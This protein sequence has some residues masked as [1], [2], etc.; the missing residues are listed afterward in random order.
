MRQLLPF[1]FE[2]P[3]EMTSRYS[4]EDTLARLRSRVAPPGERPDHSCVKGEVSAEEVQLTFHWIYRRTSATMAV[5]RGR[6]LP[7]RDG[8]QA[9][10]T[11]AFVMPLAGLL[12]GVVMFGFLAVGLLLLLLAATGFYEGPPGTGAGLVLFGALF[13]LVPL[14]R[15]YWGLWE[16][17]G[18]RAR[19]VG[20]LEEACLQ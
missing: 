9:V 4:P 17:N 20:L 8:Q 16:F 15:G 2:Q 5:F 10:L 11:G 12:F 18:D 19:I 14:A 6:L 1:F 7:H 13:T 3:W